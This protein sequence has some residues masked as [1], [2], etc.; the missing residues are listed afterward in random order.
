[1]KVTPKTEDELAD[2]QLLEPGEYS[3]RVE[4]AQ[5]K[6]SKANNEM[7]ELNLCVWAND[8]STRYVYDWLLDAVSYKV[9]HFAD[10]VGLDVMYEAGELTDDACVGRTGKLV[11]KKKPAT[12][13][14]PPKNAVAD[15]VKSDSKVEPPAQPPQQQ[16]DHEAVE[17]DDI[18]F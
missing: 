6:V 3:F 18:P 14:Y 4:S 8:G 7:I 16:G 11:L 17:G 9:K 12:N 10:A 1:M 5:E 2:A 15:Y 13:G